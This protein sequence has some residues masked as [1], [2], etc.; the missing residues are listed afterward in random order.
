ME[1]VNQRAAWAV[2]LTLWTLFF[3]CGAM[4]LSLAARAHDG[5]PLECCDHRHCKP[6]DPPRREGAYWV[7]PDGRRFL[8]G[9]TRASGEIRKL[10]FH[11]CDW[12]SGDTIPQNYEQTLIVQPKGKPVCLFVP[13]ADF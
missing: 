10:G 1:A 12:N 4:L 2:L 6:I 11:L 9:T 7:L 13:D 8:A 3:I 5:Y